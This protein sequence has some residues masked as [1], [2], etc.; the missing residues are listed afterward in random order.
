MSNMAKKKK[1]RFGRWEIIEPLGEGGQAHT[2]MVRNT[3][4][5]STG[6]VLKRLKN[7]KRIGRFKREIDSLKRLRS[8]HVP[9]VVDAVIGPEISYLVTPYV[10][11][12][13]SDLPIVAEP[14]AIFERFRGIVTAVRDSHA[15]GVI[16]RD[17]KP[18]NIVVNDSG[19]AYLVDF[20]ICADMD[21][22]VE[23]TTTIEG[24]GNA[25]FA[26][27]ECGA[28]SVDAAREA[29]DV[30]SL[31]KVLYW[32]TSGKRVFVR[33]HFEPETLTIADLH[34]AQYVSVI[35]DRTVREDPG[36]RWTSTDLLQGVDWALAKMSEHSE[37]RA[38][39]LEVITDGFGPGDECNVKASHSA[40]GSA[41]GNPPA[42]HNVAQSFFV[43]DAITLNQV[44]IALRL[45]AGSVGNAAIK[46]AKGGFA[47]PSEDDDDVLEYWPVDIADPNIVQIV[48]LHSTR[49]STLGPD[50]IYWVILSA[51]EDDSAVEWICAAEELEPRVSWVAERHGP[52]DWQGVENVR[53]PG[54]ALRILG[55]PVER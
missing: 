44:D 54:L 47:G 16:H 11:S 38:G 25:A 15:Q 31:G 1:K 48:R 14:R 37:M 34:V 33:E 23:L 39:G 52:A 45:H 55:S 20:G 53:G 51:T 6:W 40:T 12:D 13:L 2:Y 22:E 19:M 18:N 17:I 3:E 7:P 24:F 4:D 42:Q 30:Y 35:V 26:A 8:P 9:E 29:S 10:G 32:M 41:R 50:E 49:A 46:L 36:S 28:G 21:S 27:P 43:S 5:D